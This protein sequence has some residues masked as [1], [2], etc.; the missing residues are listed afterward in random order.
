MKGFDWF[1]SLTATSS[2]RDGKTEM[3]KKKY[4]LVS[5]GNSE[6]LAHP[7]K[8]MNVFLFVCLFVF[9]NSEDMTRNRRIGLLNVQRHIRSVWCLSSGPVIK[10]NIMKNECPASCLRIL[11]GLLPSACCEPPC[12]V[13]ALVYPGDD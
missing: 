5:A 4:P 6:R 8:S 10:L 9:G 2:V 13:V 12:L 7:T 3:K 1:S 11:F